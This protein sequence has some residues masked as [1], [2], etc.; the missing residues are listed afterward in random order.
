LVQDLGV[1]RSELRMGSDVVNSQVREAVELAPA[2]AGKPREI[3]LWSNRYL[4]HPLSRRLTTL[5]IPTGISPNQVS[6]LGVVASAL[7]AAAYTLIDAPVAPFVGFALHIGWHVLDGADGDLARRTGRSSPSGEVVDGV[8][9]YLSHII[10]YS[11]LAGMLSAQLGGWA[12]ALALVSGVCRAVQANSYESR[13]RTYQQWL[14]GGGWLKQSLSKDKAQ[15]DGAE[16]GGAE[17]NGV[18]RALGRT[19][20]A[21]SGLVDGQDRRLDAVLQAKLN[22][23]GVEAA[24]TKGLYRQY[25]ANAIR[26]SFPLS[27][28]ARTIALFVS[29]LFGTPLYFFLYEVVVLSLVLVATLAWQRRCNARLLEALSQAS[30]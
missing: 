10:L 3:D 22:R 5:L 16:P 7:A 6:A 23:G 13:R 1:E 11:F 12:W 9:D 21:I 8:C 25:Q 4:I 15:Q 2:C 17:V 24:R 29:M 14:Q 30:A 28:N 18:G 27:A 26:T 19:Y 20:L